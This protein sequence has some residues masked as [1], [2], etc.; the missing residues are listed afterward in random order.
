[1]SFR[2]EMKSC[3]S[4]WDYPMG[5]K[6]RIM[7]MPVRLDDSESLPLPYWRT[8]LEMLVGCALVRKGIG[9]L[10]IDEATV[11]AGQHHRRPGLHVDGI[12]P[13]GREA[14]WGG[15][16]T[17]GASGMVLWSTVRGCSAW[18]GDFDGYPGLDGD[19][20]HLRG[21]LVTKREEPMM[22]RSTSAA[23]SPCTNRCP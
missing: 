2:S 15:G 17:W 10:T 3:G 20:E 19:C 9:Y 22:G 8:T 4:W 13:D 18:L 12:G 21:E 5:T 14:A 11:P 23:R 16:G 6:T 7:M 1:M